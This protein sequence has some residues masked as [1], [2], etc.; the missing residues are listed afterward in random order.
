VYGD[1]LKDCCIAICAFDNDAAKKWAEDK[2]LSSD[3][4]VAL[5]SNTAFKKVVMEQII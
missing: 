5:E 2:N 1:S 4:L 3:D